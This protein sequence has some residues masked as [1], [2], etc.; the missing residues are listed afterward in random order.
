MNGDANLQTRNEVLGF[1]IVTDA[2]N[3]KMIL[4]CVCVCVCVCVRLFLCLF[5]SSFLFSSLFFSGKPLPRLIWWRDGRV[6]DDTF[7]VS[8]SNGVVRNELWIPALERRDFNA[9]L[10]CQASNSNLTQPVSANVTI[11]M[12]RKSSRRLTSR[13]K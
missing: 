12:E 8:P 6:V 5:F 10:I 4:F 9:T 1:R 13:E 7:T 3:V 2:P 11:D